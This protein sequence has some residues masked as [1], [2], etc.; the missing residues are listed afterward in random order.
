MRGGG[1]EHAVRRST[2]KRKH[3]SYKGLGNDAEDSSPDPP[4]IDEPPS[5]PPNKK[6]LPPTSATR[7]DSEPPSSLISK[8]SN[9]FSL[10]SREG[11]LTTIAGTDKTIRDNIL[12]NL[13]NWKDVLT[14]VPEE[15]L[16]YTVGWVICTGDWNGKG[17]ERQKSEIIQ[18]LSLSDYL[19]KIRIAAFKPVQEVTRLAVGPKSSP[20]TSDL[21]PYDVLRICML[22]IDTF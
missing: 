10:A 1:E 18:S 12:R 20:Q 5:Q 8:R 19:A 3:I 4:F 9:K 2:R 21:R 16:D 22:S 11:R 14:Q 6:R 15:L 17:G 7:E 13:E